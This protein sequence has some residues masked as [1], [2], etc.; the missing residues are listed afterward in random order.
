MP[1]WNGSIDAFLNS[2][3]LIDSSLK[4]LWVINH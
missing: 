3:G 1:E 4:V 2:Y